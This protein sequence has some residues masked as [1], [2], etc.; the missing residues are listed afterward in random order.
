[1]QEFIGT[2]IDVTEQE[3]LTK[4]LRKS[5]GE[6]RQV[7]DLAPQIILVVGPR[8]ERLYANR[9]AL[10]Y[11]GVSL[12][13]WRQR[14]HRSEVHPDDADRVQTDIDPSFGKRYGLRVGNAPAWRRRSGIAGFWSLQRAPRRPGQ[15]VR[16]YIAA[17]DIE[18]RKTRRA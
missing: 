8:R 15:I 1:V 2:G 11:Y 18:D 9:V 13:E 5:E 17:T 4:A 6:L 12:D 3:E 7:L 16:W 10:T 14:S